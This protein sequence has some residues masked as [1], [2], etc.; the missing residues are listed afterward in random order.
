M[1][2]DE[3]IDLAVMAS[4]TARLLSKSLPQAAEQIN[5]KALVI[6]PRIRKLADPL[7]NGSPPSDLVFVRRAVIV[8]CN[9]IFQERMGE[10]N[11]ALFDRYLGCN[12]LES[13]E[14]EGK[15]FVRESV[16]TLKSLKHSSEDSPE[17]LRDFAEKLRSDVLREQED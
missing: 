2:P 9:L 7:P 6:L 10:F 12:A 8:A 11:P 5:A 13:A 3:V 4:P 15:D 16:E 17:A 1:N 14:I